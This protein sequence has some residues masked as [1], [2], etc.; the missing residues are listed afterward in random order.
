MNFLEIVLIWGYNGGMEKEYRLDFELVPDA[1][2]GTNL[3][4]CLTRAQWDKVRRDAYARAEGRC[5]IC[6]KSTEKLDAHERWSYDEEHMVQKL[7]DVLAV[8]KACHMTIHIGRTQLI[9]KENMAAAHFCKV[10]G[11]SYADY[12]KRLGEATETHA[13][14]CALLGEWSL[15]LSWLKR[16]T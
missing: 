13:R 4:S 7:E 11:C 8:C 6:G 10:N 9:G 5:M 2:W 1:C 16:F 12:I 3:R 14:R 15:D